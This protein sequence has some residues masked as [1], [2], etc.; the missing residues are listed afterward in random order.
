MADLGKINSL[1]IVKK[2]DFGYYLDGGNMGEILLP[3]RYMT[4]DMKIGEPLD[5][6]VFLDGEERYVATTETPIATVGQVGYLKVKSV[7]KVGAF[8]DWGVSKELLVPFSEQK[9]KMEVGKSYIVYLYVDKITDRITGSMRLER[10]LQKKAPTFKEG[11][12]VKILVWV[13][14]DLGYKCIIDHQ[15]IGV[16]YANELL[17]SIHTGQSTSA[18]IKKIRPDGK[19]DLT[20]QPIGRT[21][22][23]HGGEVIL[24]MLEKSG[25]KLPYSDKTDP[26]VIYSIFKMSKKAFKASIGNLYKLRKIVIEDNGIKLV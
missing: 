22:L 16:L 12:A 10:F 25:G 19:V 18:Y 1:N 21:K 2:T 4:A 8:L 9:V 13:K 5:V 24:R 15:W 3:K 6:I 7:E 17:Q 11:D 20:L 26:E 14:T 23:D